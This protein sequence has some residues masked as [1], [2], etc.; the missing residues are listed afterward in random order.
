MVPAD[1]REALLASLRQD[2]RPGYLRQSDAPYGMEFAGLDVR[3]TVKDGVLRVFEVVK[4]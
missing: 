3:F 1:K 2:P 4:G